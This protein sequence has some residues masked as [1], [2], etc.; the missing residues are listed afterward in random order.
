MKLFASNLVLILPFRAGIAFMR[1][2]AFV[3][4]RPITHFT[5]WKR[6][7]FQLLRVKDVFTKLANYVVSIL[8]LDILSDFSVTD[9]FEFSFRKQGLEVK[10]VDENFFVKAFLIRTVQHLST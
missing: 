1:F 7:I 8:D 5:T 2:P 9:L 6:T 3:A 4:P 10:Y